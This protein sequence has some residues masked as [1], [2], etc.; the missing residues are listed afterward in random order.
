MDDK[1]VTISKIISIEWEM[2]TSV[3]EGLEPASC[4]EDHKT[5][6][7]MRTAQYNAWSLQAVLSY[8]DDLEEAKK[9]GRNLIEEKYIQMML[10]T[11]PSQHKALLARIKLPSETVRE[12]ANNIS[13]RLLEQTRALYSDY[14]F[15]AR[16]GRPLKSNQD[17]LFTSIETYQFAELLTYSART[18]TALL[19]HIVTLEQN[20][21]SLARL[22]LENTVKIYGYD[23]LDDAEIAAKRIGDSLPVQ[24]SSCHSCEG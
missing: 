12:S 21:V 2:F 20:G 7:G 9:A 22:I 6:T 18:L 4:Q 19:E 5:F 16:R 8:L 14:P 3:N 15:I 11:E 13:C 17:Y 23:S 1:C 24:E 10:R